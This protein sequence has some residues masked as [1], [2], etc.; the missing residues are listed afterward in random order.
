MEFAGLIEQRRERLSELEDRIS[1]PDF[2]SDQTAA[3]EV[4]REHRGLQKLM[5][6]WESYQSTARNLEEN[7]ELAKGED[8]EIA[9]MASEEIPS[10]EAALPQLK[11][12]LKYALLPQDPTEER[13]ALVEIRAGA[14]G[15]EASL[16]AG[17][18]MRM[19]ERYAE[20][21]DWKCE[22]LESSP[23]AVSYTHLTLPT[24]A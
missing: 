3:A 16:F 1:Q 22:H 14:G 19:Y 10:L 6:L 13:N 12:N 21:C 20:H 11:E 15:D 8:E 24:K 5:I 9:E 17:E 23:S 2:Y 7:R 18:V 4:M